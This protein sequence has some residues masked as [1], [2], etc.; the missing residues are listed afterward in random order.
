MSDTITF[1]GTTLYSTGDGIGHSFV[2]GILQRNVIEERA[3]LGTGYWLKD[4]GIDATTHTL[5]LAWHLSGPGLA[6]KRT[7]LFNLM[8]VSTGTLYLPGY[9]T[10]TN[11]RLARITNWQVVGTTN[12]EY[13]V[14]VALEFVEYP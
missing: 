5:V 2:P 11:C 6:S 4:N 12:N 7:T 14:S 9:G 13:L 1:N 3:P 10:Y 8:T